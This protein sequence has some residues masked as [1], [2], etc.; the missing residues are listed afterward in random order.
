MDEEVGEAENGDV[1][2]TRQGRCKVERR[3]VRQIN[4]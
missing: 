3:N 2:R 1:R 4:L